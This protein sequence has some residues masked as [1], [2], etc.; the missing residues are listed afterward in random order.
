MKVMLHQSQ[1]SSDERIL[2]TVEGCNDMMLCHDVMWLNVSMC[3]LDVTRDYMYVAYMFCELSTC[4]GHFMSRYRRCYDAIERCDAC[5]NLLISKIQ[6]HAT[7]DWLHHDAML[8]CDW[9][10]R[11]MQ[12]LIDKQSTKPC[13]ERL[14]A[15][16]D[17][18][19]RRDYTMRLNDAVHAKINW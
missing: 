11:C 19:L 1:R 5:K 17:A 16:N 10:M 8:R 7:N 9:T 13:N 15:S 3:W 4:T 14:I 2:G 18:M 6:S 12:R